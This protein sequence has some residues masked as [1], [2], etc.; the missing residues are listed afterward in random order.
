MKE[1]RLWEEPVVSMKTQAS[2]PLTR[3]GGGHGSFQGVADPKALPWM[4]IAG[5]CGLVGQVGISYKPLS[6]STA[7]TGNLGNLKWLQNSSISFS[8]CSL[9]LGQ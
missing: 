4:L 1:R 9:F 2:L 6:S 8:K 7:N 3:G 5:G